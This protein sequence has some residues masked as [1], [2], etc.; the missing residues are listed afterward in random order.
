MVFYAAL[1]MLIK[2]A[3]HD[4]ALLLCIRPDGFTQPFLGKET[5]QFYDNGIMTQTLLKISRRMD[6]YMLY[7]RI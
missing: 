6:Q 5:T 2:R 3:I 1:D 4:R 7:L